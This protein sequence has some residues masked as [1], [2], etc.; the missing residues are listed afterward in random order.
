MKTAMGWHW[1]DR[2]R[3]LLEWLVNPKAR[4]E[5]N[6]R[7]AY[8][9][10]KQE[11]LLAHCPV[12]RRRTFVDVGSHIGLWAWNFAHWFDNVEAFEPVTEH[13]ECWEKNMQATP[14]GHV[15]KLWP[16][17]LGDQPA[18]VSICTNA[19]STGDSWVKGKGTIEQRTLDSFAFT[20]VDAIKI[21]CE[22]GEELVLHGAIETIKQWKPTICVEQKR[23]M[24]QEHFDLKPLGALVFLKKLGYTTVAEKSGDYVLVH[25][26]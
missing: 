26:P 16:C 21:D 15:A 14:D 6:G 3:H 23:A 10:K 8:Q 22:G 4:M 19:S 7:L 25:K 20:D 18:M 11:M 2:E 17:A 1:P 12:D 9:G 5:L 24:A 13:R